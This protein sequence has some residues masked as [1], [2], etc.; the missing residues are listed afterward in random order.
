MCSGLVSSGGVLFCRFVLYHTELC[1]EWPPRHVH[2]KEASIIEC[3][4]QYPK[5]ILFSL[6]DSESG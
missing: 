1:W 4:G 2:I 6:H 3:Y 5:S